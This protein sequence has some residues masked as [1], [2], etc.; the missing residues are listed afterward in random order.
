MENELAQTEGLDSGECTT[1]EQS[2]GK[3][4]YNI[5]YEKKTGFYPTGNV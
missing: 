5:S 2:V 4:V 1:I 3:H